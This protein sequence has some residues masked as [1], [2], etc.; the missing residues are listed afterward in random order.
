MTALVRLEIRLIGRSI[1]KV[2]GLGMTKE[3][4]TFV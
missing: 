4:A 2:T 1:E 3:R